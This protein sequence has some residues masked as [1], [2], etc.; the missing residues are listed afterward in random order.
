M[1]LGYY[2]QKPLLYAGKVGSGFNQE[3]LR[4]L[5]S[6]L[7]KHA[8]PSCPFVNLPMQTR[9]RL[10]TG[11]TRLAMKQVTWL[12]PNLVA[13]VRFTEWTADG[14]LR[15]PVFVGLRPDQ[16]TLEVHR[17]PTSA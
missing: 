8:R 14:L 10:G 3:S 6:E 5:H 1:L 16:N 7:V 17:E 15:H 11:M 13:Q 2:Q 12:K 9:P 4:S